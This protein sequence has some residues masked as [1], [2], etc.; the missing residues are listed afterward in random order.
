[1]IASIAAVAGTAVHDQVEF[2][3]PSAQNTLP[4][5]AIT[6]ALVVGWHAAPAARRA[7]GRALGLVGLVLLVGGA[8]ASVLPLPIWP[9][10]PEQTAGHYAVHAVWAIGL[11]PLLVA[12]HDP[13]DPHAG[14][15]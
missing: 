7:V 13:D 4:F 2:G 3:R 12:H 6:A 15:P 14:S 5:A 1:M 9:F 8:L 11:L 10:T